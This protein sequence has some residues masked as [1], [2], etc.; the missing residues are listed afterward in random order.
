MSF[1]PTIEDFTRSS[2]AARMGINNTLPDSLMPAAVETL[3]MIRRIHAALSAKAGRDVRIIISSGYRC[4]ELNRAIGS[5]DTSDHTAARALDWEAP[6]FGTP[7]Q[8]CRFLATLVDDLDIGQ[9]INEFP[10]RSGWIHTSTRR[11][12]NQANR[13]ITISRAGTVAGIVG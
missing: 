1:A 11:P 4:R 8:V 5:K 7:T 10:D 13:V 2:T 6:D 12:A 9:L 3:A